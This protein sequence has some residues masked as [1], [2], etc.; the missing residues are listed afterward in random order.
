MG[1]AHRPPRHNKDTT[2]PPPLRRD[3]TEADVRALQEENAQLREL[4]VQLTTL[5]IKDVLD[6][7]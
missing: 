1:P 7:I 5:A 6:R 4:V 3:M 2:D